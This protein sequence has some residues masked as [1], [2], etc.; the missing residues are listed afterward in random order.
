MPRQ[1]RGHSWR[2]LSL[3]RKV[4]FSWAAL[5]M[6]PFA[7]M[8]RAVSRSSLLNRLSPFFAR[9]GFV[10]AAILHL[11]QK[12]DFQSLRNFRLIGGEPGSDNVTQGPELIVVDVFP[13]VFGKPKQENGSIGTDPD[14]H[15]EPTSLALPRPCHPLLDDV[16][17]KIGIDQTSHGIF[18]GDYKAGIVDARAA[19]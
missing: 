10:F 4:I 12:S 16:T 7:R 18:D 1:R 11:D 5:V 9:L 13:L 15:T 3:C 2:R 8:S 14:E 6:I 19:G 17:A